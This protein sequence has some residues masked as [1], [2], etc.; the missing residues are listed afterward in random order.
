MGEALAKGAVLRISWK[1]E[2]LYT[3][4]NSGWSRT[5][6]NY[7]GIG[8]DLRTFS[9]REDLHLSSGV[10]AMLLDRAARADDLHLREQIKSAFRERRFLLAF[11]LAITHPVVWKF[12][13]LK[14]KRK[15][16]TR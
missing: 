15:T 6:L 9:E 2:Y 7:Q 14:A 12:A 16:A 11:A 3:T 1:P 4:R 10:R 5:I 8:A 13:F